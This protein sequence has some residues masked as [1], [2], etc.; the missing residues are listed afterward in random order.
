[1]SPNS[2]S[3]LYTTLWVLG[4]SSLLAC[5]PGQGQMP[6]VPLQPSAA[7][8]GGSG[9]VLSGRVKTDLIPAEKLL[10]EGKYAEAEGL[11]REILV[12]NPTDML[13]TVGLGTALAKQFK[14]DSAD[15]LFDRVLITDPNNA[16][17]YAGKSTIILNRL[18]SSSGSIRANRDSMLKL[19]EDDAQRACALAPAMAEAHYSLGAVLKEEGK[20]DQ[21]SS[22]FRNALNFDPQHAY[23]LSGLGQIKLDQGSLS[24]A[25]ANFKSSINVNSGNSSAHYGLGATYA[26][27]RQSSMMPSKSS[28]FR[29]INFPMPGPHI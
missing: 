15:S 22:E 17:A 28:I 4:L 3:R 24:E 8:T 6:G 2:N 21:A 18:Q 25:E 9:Q 19:A 23:A 5:A 20:L 16:Q 13:A 12:A 26:K 1:M 11:F 29:F 14:L 10:A 27:E 7:T